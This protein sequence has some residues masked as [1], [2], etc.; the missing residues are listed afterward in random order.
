[1]N[2]GIITRDCFNS[3]YYLNGG[4]TDAGTKENVFSSTRATKN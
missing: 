3:P 2:L 1:M 4:K